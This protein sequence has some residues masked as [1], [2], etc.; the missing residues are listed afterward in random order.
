MS[1]TGRN[2]AGHERHPDDY[3]ATPPFVTRQILSHVALGHRPLDPCAGDGAILGAL[4][5]AQGV[6]LGFEIDDGRAAIAR[7][8][9][10]A[11]I[12][13]DAMSPYSWQHSQAS[14]VIM[15]PPFRLALPF[16]QRALA[17]VDGEVAALLR[18]AFLE[19]GRR[20]AFHRAFPA[21]V[22]VLANR[23]SFVE[24]LKWRVRRCDCYI[25]RAGKP[26]RCDLEAGHHD[27][28]GTPC[29]TL[30]TD[31]SAYAWFVW[32][33]PRRTEPGRVRVLG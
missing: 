4:H 31:S 1:S 14:G 22:F 8:K 32:R 33:W 11:V 28:Q 12:T 15:N 9:L 26:V 17:E 30:G 18:L 2:L 20:V 27:S 23:P 13:H 29:R 7:Q 6:G 10:L 3:Y 21:D 24:H 16:V 5:S 19:S 25:T